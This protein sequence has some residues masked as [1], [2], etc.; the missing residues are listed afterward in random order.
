MNNSYDNQIINASS[1]LFEA[2]KSLKD[3]DLELSNSLLA[4]ATSC[5]DT[6]PDIYEANKEVIEGTIQELLE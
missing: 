4:L 2:S 5:I 6:L 3:I 1:H